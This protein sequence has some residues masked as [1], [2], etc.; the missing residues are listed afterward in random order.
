MLQAPRA[1][2]ECIAGTG[3]YGQQKKIGEV[4]DE[5]R[6]PGQA[7]V[8]IEDR[9]IQPKA[10]V[11]APEADHFGECGAKGHRGRHAVLARE[12]QQTGLLFGGEPVVA[13]CHAWLD[14][15]AGFD[16]GGQFGRL[17]QIAETCQPVFA[18]TVECRCTA[19]VP[20][21]QVLLERGRQR[22][23]GVALVPVQ[24]AELR[25]HEPE[26][27]CIRDQHA[28]LQMQAAASKR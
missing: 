17:R 21:T 11:A 10:Q 4:S 1:I 8:P 14:N 28:D 22:L 18:C 16:R 7:L 9:Q 19:R 13:T 20:S 24:R 6:C 26:A 5:L 3:V 12:L 25:D 23:K 15:A 27:H 2:D